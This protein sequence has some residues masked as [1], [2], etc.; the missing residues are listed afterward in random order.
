MTVV[1]LTGEHTPEL[2]IRDL[3]LVIRKLLLNSID[4][5]LVPLIDGHLQQFTSILQAAGELIDGQYDGF[6][7]SA[8]TAQG[9]CPFLITPYRGILQLTKD[10]SQTFLLTFIVKDTP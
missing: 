4:S 7:G 10:F 9:L 5:S 2:Q 3:L 6:K 8:F 1:G